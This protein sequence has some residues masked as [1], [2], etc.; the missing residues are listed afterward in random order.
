VLKASLSA[1]AFHLRERLGP[2]TYE[3]ITY[4]DHQYVEPQTNAN[5]TV[6]YGEINK[7]EEK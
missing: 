3:Q 4:Q 5:Q 6:Y 1:K 2:H 7:A